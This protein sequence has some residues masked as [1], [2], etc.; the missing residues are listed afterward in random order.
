MRRDW[1]AVGGTEGC[2]C[3]AL[4]DSVSDVSSPDP[5]KSSSGA[6]GT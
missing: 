1:D 4:L 2:R 6:L 3:G 5:V